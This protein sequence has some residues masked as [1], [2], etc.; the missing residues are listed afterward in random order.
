MGR[1]D[2]KVA[3]IT[4]AARGMGASHAR[5]FIREG[6]SVVLTDRLGEEGRALAAELGDRAAFVE[7]DVTSAQSWQEVV[8]AA[9][10]R[11]GPPTV[12]VNN[13]GI[14]L[15]HGLDDVTVEDYRKVVE[16]NQIGV[17]L[18]M[19]AVLPSMRTAG[20]GSIIN[21]ASTMS[22]RGSL[23]IFAYG[24]SKWAVRGMTKSAA[25]ELAEQN[26]RVNAVHPSEIATPM[27]D[28]MAAAGSPIDPNIL[29]VKRFGRPEE[30]SAVVLFLASD[31]SSFVTGADYAVD[32]G[33]LAA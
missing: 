19:K 21:I 1:L 26:I 23:G 18:G 12:L 29:P 22:V 7:G 16:I 4:G 32:G 9:D 14:L 8:A 27:I 25:L 31:E 15:L 28:E 17:L 5:T 33:F 13:A 30:V 6:A 2:G 3:I 10:K 24:A 11:F 20:V